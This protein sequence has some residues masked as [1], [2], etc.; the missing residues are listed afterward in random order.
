[1]IPEELNRL[2]QSLQRSRKSNPINRLRIR[3]ASTLTILLDD[4]ILAVLVDE[5]TNQVRTHVMAALC[6]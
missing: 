1:M 6:C 5:E 2:L 3:H 4:E